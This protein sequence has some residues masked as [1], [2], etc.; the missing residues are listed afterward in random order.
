MHRAAHP[1]PVAL[2]PGKPCLRLRA[3]QLLA[4]RR[5]C[6]RKVFRVGG[7]VGLL[8]VPQLLFQLPVLG[9]ARREARH[10]WGWGWGWG[11]GSCPGVLPCARSPQQK[12]ALPEVGRD[13]VE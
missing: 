10:G 8:A 12:A 2:C 13:L 5:R 7:S 4:Q 1:R 6:L 3:L 11:G 9:A